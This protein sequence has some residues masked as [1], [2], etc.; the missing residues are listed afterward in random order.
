MPVDPAEG[1]EAAANERRDGAS[2][3]H[4]DSATG[5]ARLSDANLADAR[6]QGGRPFKHSSEDAEEDGKV[7]ISR[8]E[9]A[10]YRRAFGDMIHILELAV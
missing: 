6:Q 4:A 9:E 3:L 8:D 1:A 7:P 2:Q 5:V 10:Q